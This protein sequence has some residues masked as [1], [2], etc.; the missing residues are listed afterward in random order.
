MLTAKNEGMKV[1]AFTNGESN[2]DFKIANYKIDR[3]KDFNIDM[4]N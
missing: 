1:M 2:I 4:F 3:F